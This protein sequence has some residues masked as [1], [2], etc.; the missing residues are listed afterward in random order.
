MRQ[1]LVE[2]KYAVRG[3]VVAKADEMKKK[4]AAGEKLPFKE[5]IPCNIGNPHAVR[6]KPITFYRNVLACCACPA[7]CEASSSGVGNLKEGSK[8]QAK[9][10]GEWYPAKVLAIS[11]SKKRAKAP[12]KV[13]YTGFDADYDEWKSV[14]DLKSKAL[15]QK[16]PAS[17]AMSGVMPEDVQARAR[18]Y[19]KATGG[20]G[21]GAYTGSTGLKFVREQIAAFIEQRDGFPAD[22]ETIE[23]H[24]GASEGVKRVIQALIGKNNDSLM[25]P[26]PQYPLYSASLTMFGG[27]TQYYICK[28]E[29]DWS[30]TPEEL[31]RSYN[32]AKDGKRDVRAIAVINPGNPTGS[33]LSLDDVKMFITFARDKDIPILADEVYQ[34]N[35]YAEGKEFHSFK[36]ALR[37]LQKEDSSYSDVQLMSFH[38]TSKGII[39]ECGLR[40][41]YTEF[42]GIPDD[43]MSIFVK[44]ASTSLSSNTLGQ[45]C[46]GLMVTPPTKGQ[47]SYKLFEKETKAIFN[48]LKERARLLTE[49]LEAIP[50]ITSREIQGAMYAFAKVEIPERA[51]KH[52]VEQELAA[53]EFWCLELVEKA[54]IVCVPGSGFGQ[55]PGTFHFR[56]TILPPMK[57]LK[58]MI[59]LLKEFQTNFLS[60]WS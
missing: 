37:M 25:I 15:P 43:V 17:S 9:S 31:E 40:G 41:G 47:P 24:T 18:E 50:G 10:E 55:E 11:A 20:N 29:F 46:C 54:G 52:A 38:S 32:E 59:V 21:I 58:E 3:S 57:M 28:E 51:V 45:I 48:G 26:K 2:M 19:L 34:A 42:I 13:H 4:L 14:N 5:I 33:V 7:L 1:E 30:V 23:L 44:V 60:T 39:G 53:D 35:V 27:S 8:V 12:V 22:P 16:N 49:G 36:K 6:Q 56:I